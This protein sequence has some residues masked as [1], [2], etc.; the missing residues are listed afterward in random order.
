MK[1]IRTVHEIFD[2]YVALVNKCDNL[3]KISVFVICE[4][5]PIRKSSENETKFKL[6]KKPE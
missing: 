3:F 6:I 1:Y 2:E 4:V 5:I